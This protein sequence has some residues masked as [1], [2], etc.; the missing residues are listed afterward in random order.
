[1]CQISILNFLRF[2]SP[3]S[4]RFDMDLHRFDLLLSIFCPH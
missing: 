2:I 1:M 3:D 4:H